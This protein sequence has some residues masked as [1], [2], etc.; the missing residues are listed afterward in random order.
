MTDRLRAIL[1]TGAASG[2]GRATALRLARPGTGLLIHTRKNAQGAEA[3][4]V[5]ARARG[6]AAEVLLG[7]LGQSGAPARAVEA[8][9]R[10]FGGLDVLISNA[11]FADKT[12]LTQ[13]DPARIEA[14]FAAGPLA[15]QALVAS[16]RPQLERSKDGRVIAVGSFVSHVIRAGLPVFPAT[17]A[18]KAALEAWARL[19]ALELAPSGVTAN[20]V[21]P[22][23]TR[24]DGG[25][26]TAMT[27][28]QWREIEAS[29]PLGRRAYPDEVAAVI[30]FLASPDASYV[31]GQSIRVDGGLA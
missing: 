4:A 14:S 2:I 18:A 24:K 13:L 19:L 26:H 12:P 10:A 15:F 30:A 9:V 21:V 16:A 27:P 3:V 8:T 5:E 11:G 29:I 1:V 17:A 25:A 20:V 28:E 23:F 31:T 6:S 7:D 22:G